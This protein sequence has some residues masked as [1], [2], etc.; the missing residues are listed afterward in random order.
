M[1]I[2]VDNWDTDHPTANL[3]SNNNKTQSES[4]IAMMTEDVIDTD[5]GEATIIGDVNDI[6]T[7]GETS[8]AA[9]F[10]GLNGN[11]TTTRP[12]APNY[13]IRVGTIGKIDAATGSIMVNIT[14]YNFTDTEVNVDGA[15]NGICPQRQIHSQQKA[16]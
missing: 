9:V 8:G 1:I 2:S 6:N 15:L 3:A 11:W 7:F 5:N 16:G 10:L 4:V 12:I 13:V 14:S